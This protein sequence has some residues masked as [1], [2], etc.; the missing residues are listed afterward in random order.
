MDESLQ[1]L[2]GCAT[3]GLIA[4]AFAILFFGP[5][6]LLVHGCRKQQVV[7]PLRLA[8]I[9]THNYFFGYYN[10]LVTRP[11]AKVKVRQEEREFRKNKPSKS[12]MIF[13]VE[14]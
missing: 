9:L 10:T 8:L 1:I 13:E 4:A 5:K 14:L 7:G 6:R 11:G 3:G 2:A 12:V